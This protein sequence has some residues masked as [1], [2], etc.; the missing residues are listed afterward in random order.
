M[1]RNL[2][3]VITGVVLLTMYSWRVFN[4]LADAAT[5]L[6]GG[7]ADYPNSFGRPAIRSI[8]SNGVNASRPMFN[9]SRDNFNENRQ[10]SVDHSSALAPAGR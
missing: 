3:P 10:N 6:G 2:V 9:T 7:G 8:N 1:F 5:G 4:G